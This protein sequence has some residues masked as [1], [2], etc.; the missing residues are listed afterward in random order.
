MKRIVVLG[1]TS[2]IAQR[3]ARLYAARG[4]SFFLAARNQDRVQAVADDLRARGAERAEIAVADLDD[5]S[6]HDELI[7]GA[8]VAL[9]GID[10][11]IV[12]HGL[13]GTR[14]AGPEEAERVLRT[15]L[16]GPVSL[17]LRAALRLERQRSGAIVA[18]SSV[19]GDR[20]R[21]ANAAYGAAKAGLSAFLSALRQR[22]YRSGV[23]VV[24]VKPGFV[25]TPMTAH[26]AHK[27]LAVPPDVVARDVVRALDRGRDVVYTPWIWRLVMLVVRAIPERMFKR[28]SF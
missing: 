21:A 20:G 27:P 25:D 2:A 4:A 19:A 11:L 3:I 22:L 7:E 16:V 12:A 23:R 28:L 6:R 17:L 8:Q 13:L 9:S 5:S 1:A 26:L 14:D 10:L 24:T 18:L 15:G